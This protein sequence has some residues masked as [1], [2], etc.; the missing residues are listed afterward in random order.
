METVTVPAAMTALPMQENSQVGEARRVAMRLAETA[1]FDPEQ[2]MRIGLIATESAT[3]LVKHAKGG[4]LLVRAFEEEG[5]AGVEV[6]AVDRGPGMVNVQRCLEDGFSTAGSAGTGLGA[7]RRLADAFDVYSLPALG[8]VLLARV[9][10]APPVPPRAGEV[11]AVVVPIPGETACGDACAFHCTPAHS[12]FLMVDGLGHGPHAA[13]AAQEAVRVFQQM[14]QRSPKLAMQALHDALRKTRGA[15]IAI[16]TLHRPSGR[17][18]YCSVGNISTSLVRGGAVKLLPASNGIVGHAMR[19]L[20]E[21]ALPWAGEGLLLMHSDGLRPQAR[22]EAYPGLF[23]RPPAL[24]AGMLYGQ[25]KRGR[26]D[27]SVLVAALA[28]GAP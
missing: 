14:P 1:R 26:D 9:F 21:I 13:D 3:N 7:T 6:L 5:N 12:A 19:T 22:F 23:A 11:G 27:A 10:R 24:I 28:G 16:A 4:E 18:G 8:T 20:E 15:A 25:Q 2:T 17:L